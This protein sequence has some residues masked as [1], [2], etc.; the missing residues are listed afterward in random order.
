MTGVP[1]IALLFRRLSASRLFTIAQIEGRL[2]SGG[3]EFGRGLQIRH[4][5]MEFAAIFR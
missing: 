4:A 3:S 5:E 1:S 2:R